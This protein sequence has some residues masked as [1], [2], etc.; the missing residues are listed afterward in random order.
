MLAWIWCAHF[1]VK[2]YFILAFVQNFNYFDSSPLEFVE[3]RFLQSRLYSHFYGSMSQVLHPICPKISKFWNVGQVKFH[4][5]AVLYQIVPHS[6]RSMLFSCTR[7]HLSTIPIK[8]VFDIF[9]SFLVF[10]WLNFEYWIV[11]VNRLIWDNFIRSHGKPKSSF[12]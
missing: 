6:R 9:K 8:P 7:T 3:W 1:C 5:Q 12:P 10:I 11:V 4:I 2:N